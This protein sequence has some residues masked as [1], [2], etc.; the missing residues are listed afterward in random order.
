MQEYFSHPYFHLVK[1]G[2]LNVAQISVLLDYNALL[3]L[4]DGKEMQL[5]SKM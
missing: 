2:G 3:M 4:G 5:G 1:S